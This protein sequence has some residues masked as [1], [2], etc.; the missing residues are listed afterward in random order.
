M[1]L[2]NPQMAFAG[3]RFIQKGGLHDWAF[4]HGI[5]PKSYMVHAK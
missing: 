1:I 4:S 2:H 3:V 5:L